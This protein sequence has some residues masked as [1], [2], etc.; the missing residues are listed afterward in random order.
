MEKLH[1]LGLSMMSL[2]YFSCEDP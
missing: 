2:D 1:S